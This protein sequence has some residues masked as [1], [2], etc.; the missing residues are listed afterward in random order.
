M[1][2]VSVKTAEIV[3][4]DASATISSLRAVGY[5]IDAAI[6]DVIDN[7]ITA[8]ARSISIRADWNDG[9][10][11]IAIVDDGLGMSGEQLVAAM[12]IGSSDP[13]AVRDSGDLG[14]FGLGLK[15]ASF[16]QASKVTVFSKCETSDLVSRVWDLDFVRSSKKWQLLSDGI[17]PDSSILE[18]IVAKGRGT[19]VL[20]QNLDRFFGM[21]RES[22][23]S[24]QYFFE[25]LD[26]VRTRI[27]LLFHRYL[28]GET[29]SGRQVNIQINDTKIQPWDPFERIQY[30][31]VTEEQQLDVNDSGS[32]VFGIIL[33]H[34]D[35]IKDPQLHA[36]MTCLG[37]ITNLQGIFLYRNDRLISYGNWLGLATGDG[38]RLRKEEMYRLARVGID[39]SNASDMK[40]RV[41]IKKSMA[42]A[43][44][45][46]RDKI[47]TYA[48]MVR[49]RARKVFWHR[50]TLGRNVK[51]DTL[52]AEIPVWIDFGVAKKLR[53]QINRE[54]P[55]VQDL[56]RRV[57][58]LI[59]ESERLLKILERNVPVEKIYM[60]ASSDDFSSA[61]EHD[62]LDNEMIHALN[63]TIGVFMT[64]Q[65]Q[66]GVSSDAAFRFA[67][68][69]A[70][71]VEPFCRFGDLLQYVKR[72]TQ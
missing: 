37:S 46:V 36:R 39:I 64:A 57:P 52:P 21:S 29:T 5:R 19:A 62:E 31:Q 32:R 30:V 66:R 12:R 20:W 69:L 50:A 34:R 42:I 1:N 11:W 15:T 58:G 16:S 43:P 7:S 45:E 51:H 28:T 61:P 38:V 23:A 40:W 18:D 44:P 2:P 71:K 8:H 27:G 60:H 3:E 13:E 72:R 49:D 53:Y 65:L 55:L 56:F 47:L 41:D 67:V 4:P 6:A 70:S 48:L 59:N 68:D 9:D 33:P 24:R 25:Q 14:R 35:H 63:D 17:C 22:K 10:A 26:Y 54:H